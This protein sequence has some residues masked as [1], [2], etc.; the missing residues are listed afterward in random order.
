VAYGGRGLSSEEGGRVVTTEEDAALPELTVDDAG[1][2]NVRGGVIQGSTIHIVNAGFLTT[3]F[4]KP[5]IS[6]EGLSDRA[7]EKVTL[8]LHRTHDHDLAAYRWRRAAEPLSWI[9]AVL[10]AISGLAVVGET[11]LWPLG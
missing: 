2:V 11:W 3:S 4:A 5:G 7:L 6:W 9:T 1:V 10:A 8:C